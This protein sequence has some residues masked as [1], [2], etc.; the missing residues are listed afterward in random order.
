MWSITTYSPSLDS[1][2]LENLEKDN[3]LDLSEGSSDQ[4]EDFSIEE[5]KGKGKKR[6]RSSSAVSRRLPSRTGRASRQTARTF[7][8]V[9]EIEVLRA[10]VS[11]FNVQNYQSYPSHIPTYITAVAGP[12]KYPPRTFC[13]VTGNFASYTNLSTG[14]RFATM[15]EYKYLEEKAS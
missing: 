3:Y 4:A 10:S 8:Q 14:T 7:N 11:S 13:R 6:A 5:V 15:R 12:S 2:H 1:Q 9:L